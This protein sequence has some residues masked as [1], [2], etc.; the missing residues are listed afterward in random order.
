MDPE[1]NAVITGASSVIGRAIATAIAS[2]GAAVCLVGRN[3]ERLEA[4]AQKVR[5]TARSV[6]SVKS[7]L[8]VDSAVQDLACRLEAEFRPLD[9]LVHCAGAFT[10]GKIEETA[11]GQLDALFG[12][13]VRLPFAL[14]QAL[15]PSAEIAAGSDRLH[16][17]VARIGSQSHHRSLC[18][19]PTRPQG[20]R[21]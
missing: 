3:A 11:L 9:V 7:D 15:L 4:V 20:S 1:L 14:T 19:N 2:T 16:Q 10:T 6:L 8:T 17:L 13:N 21:R 12:A 5:P 18:S